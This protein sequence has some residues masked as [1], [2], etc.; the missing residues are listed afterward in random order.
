MDF[1]VSKMHVVMA[2]VFIWSKHMLSWQWFS[3]EV[4]VKHIKLMDIMV[5]K[6]HIVMAMVFMVSK[7]VVK[8]I[9]C[10]VTCYQHNDLHGR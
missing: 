9:V 8:A 10:M 5:S 3:L 4:K 6:M 1:M 2:M 7:H